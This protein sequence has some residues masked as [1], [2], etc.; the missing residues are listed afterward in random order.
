MDTL[1]RKKTRRADPSQQRDQ[2]EPDESRK[3]HQHRVGFFFLLMRFDQE[4]VCDLLPLSDPRAPR[5]IQ[6]SERRVLMPLLPDYLAI[7][8]LFVLNTGV[9]DDVVCS[10]KWEWEARGIAEI[11]G[12]SIFI[13]PIEHV[14]GQE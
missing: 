11:G 13:I 10:L 9:R 7:M 5:P 1:A 6:W 3:Q 2:P 4:F 12:N 8:A 14:K